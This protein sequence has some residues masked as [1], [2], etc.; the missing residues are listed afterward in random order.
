[1]E[2]F[3]GDAFVQ[4]VER[5]PLTDA[6]PGAVALRV[7]HGQTED[8]ILIA[9]QEPP[10]AAWAPV[11]GVRLRGRLAVIRRLAG[12]TQ[13]L[14]VFDGE[15]I[16]DGDMKL[17]Q[18]AARYEGALGSAPRRA[19]GTAEDAFITTADLPMGEA[20]R[21]VWMVG[22]HAGGFPHGY[23]SER[24]EKRD[25]KTAIILSMDHG[26]RV[27]EDAT[28]EVYFP[29]RTFPEPNTFGISL[30]AHVGT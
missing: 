23:P 28:Q 18:L 13:G 16:A 10:F 8:L 21:G 30:S 3:A 29:Q 14:W 11:D 6:P 12:R 19:D 26:L 24:V 15:G 1:M 7:R 9:T 27:Q 2:P 25:G 22:T 17:T 5:R 4:S 20:L